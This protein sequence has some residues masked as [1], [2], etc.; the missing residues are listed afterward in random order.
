MPIVE[1]DGN[2]AICDGGGGPLGHPNEYISLAVPGIVETC[3]YC[4]IRYTQ[5]KKE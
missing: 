3:K 1:V 2:M 5:K 4:G